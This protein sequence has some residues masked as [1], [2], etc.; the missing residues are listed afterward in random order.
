MKPMIII[1]YVLNLR[2]PLTILINFVLVAIYVT[3][4]FTLPDEASGVCLV[5]AILVSLYAY[6][7]WG[8][9]LFRYL[10]EYAFK[11]PWSPLLPLYDFLALYTVTVIQNMALYSSIALLQN[12]AFIGIDANDIDRWQILYLSFFL[13]TETLSALGTGSIFANPFITE[14][15]GFIP[16][17][18]ES[19]QALL[20]FTFIGWGSAREIT[21]YPL[22]VKSRLLLERKQSNLSLSKRV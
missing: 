15:V 18:I 14:S 1:G 20:M 19:I 22:N 3:L 7:I 12:S 8:Y 2:S 16:V 4:F 9:L 13:A 21:R 5:V 10:Y 6:C 11:P 17:W